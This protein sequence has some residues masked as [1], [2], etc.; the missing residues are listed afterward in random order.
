MGEP[1]YDWKGDACI[2]PWSDL[3]TDAK[4]ELE[5]VFKTLPVPSSSPALGVMHTCEVPDAG[6]IRAL[7]IE[8]DYCRRKLRLRDQITIRCL[9]ELSP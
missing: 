4:D 9:V 5:Q 3:C 8:Y 2:A 6:G 1:R 7:A